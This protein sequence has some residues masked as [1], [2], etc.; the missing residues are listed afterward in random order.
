MDRRLLVEGPDDKHVMW[1]L[2]AAH[3]VEQTFVVEDLGGVERLLD[4]LR[5]RLVA[6]SDERLGVII[7]ADARLEDRWRSLRDSVG[8]A[9]PGVLPTDPDPNGTVVPL[10][11]GRRLGVWLMPDNRVPGMLEDFASLLV[12]PGD[13]VWATARA[14]VDGLRA[15]A[16]RFPEQHRAKARLHAWLAVQ[17]EPG[18]PIGQAITSKYLEATAAASATL[19]AWI[20]RLFGA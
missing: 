7:D 13:P 20:E 11:D 18:R 14:F 5:V 2:L 15:P 17:A 9:F 4:N 12:P 19:I 10:P 16:L 1:A 8:R 3:H 6:R